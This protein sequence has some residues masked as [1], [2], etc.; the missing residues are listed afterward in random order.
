MGINS[1][2]RVSY[3]FQKEFYNETDN[4]DLY[5]NLHIHTYYLLVYKMHLKNISKHDSAMVGDETTN[6]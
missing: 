4:F 5:L 2:S 6:A 1:K 3:C